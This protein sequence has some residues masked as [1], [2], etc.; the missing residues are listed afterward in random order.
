LAPGGLGL[1]YW[2]SGG[3]SVVYLNFP[4]DPHQLNAV[5]EYVPETGTEAMVATTSQFAVFAPNADASVFVGASRNKAAPHVLLLL[6][7]TRHELTVCEH[8]SGNPARVAPVFS[9]DSQ[10]IYF[11]SDRHGKPAV[12]SVALDRMVEETES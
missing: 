7:A 1:A 4:A 11:G 12:Y 10:N 5:R 2:A 9:P 8:R 3:A 6:R